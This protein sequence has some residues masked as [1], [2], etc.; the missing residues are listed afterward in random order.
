MSDFGQALADRSDRSGK[1]VGSPSDTTQSEIDTRASINAEPP[2][3][4]EIDTR[5]SINADPP[6]LPHLALVFWAAK[7]GQLEELNESI[8]SHLASKREPAGN[9]VN[10]REGAKTLN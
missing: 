7:H 8:R 10:I 9:V 5:A 4:S 6:A 1:K 3:Q 2:T